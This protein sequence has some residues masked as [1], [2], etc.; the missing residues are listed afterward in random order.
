MKRVLIAS[1]LL[2]T[3]T[4]SVSAKSPS[5]N[6]E[7]IAQI[8]SM[9]IKDIIDT[10][11]PDNVFVGVATSYASITELEGEIMAR[12][13][14]YVTPTNDFKQTYIR[15]TFNSW[16]WERSD[17]WLEYAKDNNIAL[18]LHAPI[19]PQCSKWIKADDRTP[20][21]LSRMLDEYMT[22]LCVRY[23]NHPNALWLDVVNETIAKEKIRDAMGN[24]EAGG[25]F[26]PRTGVEKWE[27]PWTTIG[28]DE[29]SELRVPLYI[30]RAFEISNML[31]PNIKQII[32]Q[33]GSFE[34]VVWNK[35]MKGLVK[36]LR[37]DKGRTLDGIGWQAH[38]DSG[39]ELIEGNME[40]LSSFIDWCHQN[41]L[42]FHIT[43]MNVWI[44]G[45]KSP[46]AF[47]AQDATYAAV[48]DV[49]LS[50]KSTGVVGLNFWG[51]CD[52]GVPEKELAGCIW[53][54]DGSPK[55][56]YSVIKETIINNIK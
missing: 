4:T 52:S 36:Y 53:N 49:L 24:V 9:P 21:E 17:G 46:E 47:A 38:I 35:T 37:E 23:N 40:R 6:K 42:E 26:G 8:M 54:D 3:A 56:A 43:E 51:V 10:F 32:N 34:E 16:R 28:F 18:R 50:K 1:L 29:Q 48:I 5:L 7:E 25:W 12:E 15:P 20:E 33:H 44:R 2:L 14:N 13:F 11:Y 55:N 30:D 45:E 27:N 41:N 31:A 22:A 39:W 19:S